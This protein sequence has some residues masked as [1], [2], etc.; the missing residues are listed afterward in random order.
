MKIR[1][2]TKTGPSGHG[3]TQMA[4]KLGEALKLDHFKVDCTNH[5]S[6][7][8]LFGIERQFDKGTD[9]KGLNT[10]IANNDGKA[11][12]VILD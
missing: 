9:S 11:A 10:F 5:K 2:L 1:N 12:I 3:K 4:S 6:S 7:K 8:D